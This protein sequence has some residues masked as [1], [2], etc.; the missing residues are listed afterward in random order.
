MGKNLLQAIKNLEARQGRPAYFVEIQKEVLSFDSSLK[1]GRDPRRE[2]IL[3][4]FKRDMVLADAECNM[5]TLNTS[6]QRKSM[7]DNTKVFELC[8]QR[9]QRLYPTYTLDQDFRF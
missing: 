1:K 3:D 2:D 4:L 6:R 7:G 9:V 5:F 8:S